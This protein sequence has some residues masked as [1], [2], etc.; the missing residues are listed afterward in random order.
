MIIMAIGTDMS[1]TIDI[2]LLT[3]PGILQGI[4]NNTMA[5]IEAVE[6]VLENSSE[7][8]KCCF[9]EMIWAPYV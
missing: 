6:T 7:S 4:M 8:L 5:A 2:A 3:N 9:F 1:P